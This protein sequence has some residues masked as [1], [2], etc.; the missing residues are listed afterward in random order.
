VPLLEFTGELVGIYYEN[1]TD[2]RRPHRLT[3]Q[4]SD[5]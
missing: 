5:Y 2:I 3:S 4:T 1:N